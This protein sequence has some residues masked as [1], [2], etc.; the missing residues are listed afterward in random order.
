MPPAASFSASS[1]SIPAEPAKSPT[2][3][4]DE[5]IFWRDSLDHVIVFGESS[6]HR[7]LTTYFAYYHEWRTHLS[8]AKDAPQAR[9]IQA[10]AEGEVAEIREVGGLHHHYERRAA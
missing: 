10:T 8:L 6:L 1:V 7:T 9:R 2:N 4:P 3:C 5:A